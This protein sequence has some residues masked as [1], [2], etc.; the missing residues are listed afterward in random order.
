MHIPPPQQIA[1]AGSIVGTEV[2]IARLIPRVNMFIFI[3]NLHGSPPPVHLHEHI[4][5]YD[6]P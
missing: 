1:V 3:Y 4:H 2:T 6:Q 5:E